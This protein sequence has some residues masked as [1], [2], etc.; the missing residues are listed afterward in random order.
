MRGEEGG[1]GAQR[2]AE[3]ARV[4]RAEEERAGA[5]TG[6]LARDADSRPSGLTGPAE[7]GGHRGVVES[8]MRSAGG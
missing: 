8:D 4:L 5:G 1:V 7:F 6:A 3:R 2:G